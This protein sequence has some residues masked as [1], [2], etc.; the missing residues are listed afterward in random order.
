MSK[1]ILKFIFQLCSCLTYMLPTVQLSH[2]II[3]NYIVSQF[4]CR[5]LTHCDLILFCHLCLHL[6]ISC[7]SRF[8]TPLL[9]TTPYITNFQL[10]GDCCR[11]V[12][13]SFYKSPQRLE[14][15]VKYIRQQ[16]VKKDSYKLA[17]DN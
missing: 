11:L 7:I 1:S 12:L 9:H 2:N 6:V 4:S 8:H 5:Q 10:L 15:T 14:C 16:A 13:S 17:K 3:V